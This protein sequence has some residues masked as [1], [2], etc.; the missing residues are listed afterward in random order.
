LW[1]R[2]VLVGQRYG[3]TI[4]EFGHFLHFTKLFEWK[5]DEETIGEW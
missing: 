4:E 3:M 2:L 1:L 5:Q